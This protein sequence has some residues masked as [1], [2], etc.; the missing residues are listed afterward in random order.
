LLIVVAIEEKLI[1]VQKFVRRIF[2]GQEGNDGFRHL[3]RDPGQQPAKASR[4]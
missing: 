2:D 4:A 1:G 3:L